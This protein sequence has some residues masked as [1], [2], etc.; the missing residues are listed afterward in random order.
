M[1]L[2]NKDV[3]LKTLE[4]DICNIYGID[5]VTARNFAK[6]HSD[7]IEESMWDSYNKELDYLMKNVYPELEEK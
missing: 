4:E 1:Y 5:R 6:D 7:M 2:I 3:L